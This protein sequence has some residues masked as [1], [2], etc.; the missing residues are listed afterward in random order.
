MSKEDEVNLRVAAAIVAA[1]CHVLGVK[2]EEWLKRRCFGEPVL[3][4]H[5]CAMN[6]AAVRLG[7][8]MSARSRVM[9][10]VAADMTRTPFERELVNFYVEM[11][12]R[13]NAEKLKI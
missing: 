13:A 12:R 3:W 9:V 6:R 5:L 11:G 2:R 7:V 10:W 8:P 1:A 4:F